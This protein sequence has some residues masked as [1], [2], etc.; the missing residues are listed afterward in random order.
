MSR[1][2]QYS[3]VKMDE[4]IT[5]KP[6][7]F[8]MN[9]WVAFQETW[10]RQEKLNRKFSGLGK[11]I[12][13][14]SDGRGCSVC[15]NWDR[16]GRIM[17]IE[18]ADTVDKSLPTFSATL[19]NWQRFVNQEIGAARAVMSGIIQYQGSVSFLLKYGRHFDYLAD[20]AQKVVP[21]QGELPHPTFG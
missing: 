17:G 14:F 9:W 2:N 4:E 11:A 19:E 5:Q 3:E 16:N 21:C 20:V 1:K 7:P 6:T 10:N 8:S 15:L 18:L 12:F 13:N